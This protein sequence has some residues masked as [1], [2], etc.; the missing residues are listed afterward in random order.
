MNEITRIHLA[1]T[2]Y[3]IDVNAKKELE[4]YLLAI[5][6][7]LGDEV[8][9]MEDIEI[10]MTEILASRGVVKD[11][12]ITESDVKA[13]KDQ[14][15]EPKVFSA[16]SEESKKG[17]EETIAD[18]V[19]SAFADKKY[20]R[21]TDNAVLGGVMSGLAAYTGWDVTL[22]RVLAVLLVLF[23]WGFL[24]ILY[25]VVWICAPAATS[26]SE[27][28]EMRG[29]PVN[30]DSIKES[31]KD[32]GRKAEKAGK[33]AASKVSS[34]AREVSQN[35]AG[36]INT[37]VRIIM[38]FFGIIGLFVIFGMVMGTIVAGNT[39]IYSVVT[40]DIA[41]KPLL[42]VAVSLAL[43]FIVSLIALGSTI[44]FALLAGHFKKGYKNSL[45]VSLIFSILLFAGACGTTTA[46]ITINGREGV[47]SVVN[48]VVDDSSCGKGWSWVRR[49]DGS[50]RAGVICE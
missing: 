4:K 47:E 41:A 14:L 32:F 30:I 7:S 2:S 33:N 24:I 36:A 43:A 50:W 34:A 19:S 42:I 22:L 26:T 16:D 9:A 21:D 12:V 5:K 48:Q 45:L 31:A 44:V 11:S 25:L 18:K 1:R 6:K 8:D 27:K 39:I 37:F 49:S 46:W 15:G 29:E 10:R 17:K 38:I 28:L 40:M 3:E 35:S 23:S 20:Y 13:I